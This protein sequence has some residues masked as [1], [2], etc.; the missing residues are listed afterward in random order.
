MFQ[1]L[2][3]IS[4][5][6]PQRKWASNRPEGKT[7]SFFSSWGRCS[8]IMTGTS[9][10]H[11]G[12]IRKGQS[13]CELLTGFSGFLSLRC[14]GLRPCAESGPQP[15]DSSPVQTWILGTSEVSPGE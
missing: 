2:D 15:E 10:T 11:S 9:G 1:S 7:S 4:L 13:P 8:R 6:K 12:G 14:L 3:V 5:E